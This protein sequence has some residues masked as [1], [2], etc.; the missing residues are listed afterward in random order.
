MNKMYNEWVKKG[1][2]KGLSDIE[3]YATDATNLS[4]ELYESKVEKN[5]ISKMNVVLIKGI[6]NGKAAKVKVE[7]FSEENIDF[8]LDALI[9]SA[10]NITADEPALIFEGSKEYNLVEEELFDFSAIDPTLKVD[11]LIKLEQ[12][13]KQNEFLDKVATVM[14]SETDSQTVIVN[15]KGL[16]L[17]KHHRYAM[18]YANGIYK[19]G[20]QVKSGS[21]YKIVKN[22]NDFNI[23]ELIKENIEDGTSQLGA[24]SLSTKVYPT[25]FSNE[26]FSSI[27]AVFEDIF[28]GEAAF[29]KVTKLLGKENTKI[30]NEIV[31]LVD[32]PFHEKALFKVPFDDE[33][34]AT[35]KRYW[36]KDGVFTDF[37]HNLKTAEIFKTTSTGNGYTS[38]ISSSNLCLEPGYKTLDEIF[39]TIDNGVYITSLV[40]LHA[41]VESVSGDFS[42]QAAGFEIVDGKKGRPVDMLVVSGNFFKL[43]NDIE[44]IGNDFKFGMYGVGT[45][46]VKVKGLTIAG[47]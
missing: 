44:T 13:I 30:A 11:T 1:L 38:G 34:V 39:E 19:Q 8:M 18:I 37:A 31:N 5:E 20:E 46:S 21:S 3:I 27:L 42:L 23:D 6:Y 14:Y 9:D 17:S 24:S 36:I 28:T 45:A 4:I 16:N 32:D 29:R 15:S 26:M 22:F 43:L 10:S 12:G 25:V 35:A 7:D 33:G 40:G 2:A 47:Q 41:G